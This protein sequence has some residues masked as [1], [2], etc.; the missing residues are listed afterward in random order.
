MVP[1]LA[2]QESQMNR[3]IDEGQ[4][5]TL[6]RSSSKTAAD[7]QHYVPQ[8]LLK[9]FSVPLHHNQI[10]VFDKHSEKTFSANIRNV[11]SEKGF[12][13]LEIGD[14][15]YTLEDALKHLEDSTAKIIKAVMETE[16]LPKPDSIERY[17]LAAFVAVQF[18]RVKSARIRIRSMNDLLKQKLHCIG[19]SGAD[20]ERL[21]RMEE[22][23][24]KIISM[25][26]L[27]RIPDEF[28][29][30]FYHKTW[31]VLKTTSDNPF[32]ISDNP[33]TLQN[34]KDS[35]LYG[36]LGLGVE[37]V[38]IY[39][40]LSKQLSLGILCPSHEEKVN[41]VHQQFSDLRQRRPEI[42]A[43]L[44]ERAT[45]LNDFNTGI[46]SGAAI[47]IPPEVALNLNSLQ[48]Y[49]SSRFVY[50]ARDKFDLVREM[51]RDN[52]LV[53]AGPPMPQLVC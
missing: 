45:W 31:I 51:I 27:E 44:G 22:D 17:V 8:F 14:L 29:P 6:T 24:S 35:G 2:A 39:M 42:I 49:F 7:N 52:P 40:P 10:M 37:G 3:K 53:K 28:V 23:E 48:V 46:K 43:K 4:R 20:I 50:C 12:Y 30:F 38:E 15:T 1:M 34:R 41:K 19:A 5:T 9:N 36:N 26:M 32:F 16:E 33:V 13:D 18:L 11:S 21:T 47:R 25:K